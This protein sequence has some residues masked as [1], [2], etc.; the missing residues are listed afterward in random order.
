VLDTPGHSSGHVT[1]VLR[2]GGTVAAFCGD[3]LFWGGK[4][5]LQN[6]WD[7]SLQESIRSVEKLAALSLDALY[8][9]HVSFVLKDARRHVDQAM[10]SIAGLLPPPQFA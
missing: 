1:Y 5:L 3:A 8:P 10:R 9:G 7:C 2:R 4:I 6:T